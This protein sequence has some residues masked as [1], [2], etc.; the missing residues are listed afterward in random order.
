MTPLPRGEAPV[1]IG[2][3]WWGIWRIVSRLIRHLVSAMWSAASSVIVTFFVFGVAF[4]LIAFAVVSF[5]F[6][7]LAFGVGSFSC[8][9]G[10]LASV[11]SLAVWC[12]F[13]FCAAVSRLCFIIRVR[14]TATALLNM[15]RFRIVR[16]VAKNAKLAPPSHHV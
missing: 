10:F 5:C 7:S 13:F 15:I 4:G 2:R 16:N 14:R 12:W 3:L 9:G 6:F 8:S 11:F 1:G